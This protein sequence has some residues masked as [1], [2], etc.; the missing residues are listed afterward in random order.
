MHPCTFVS[1]P[2]NLVAG[3]YL[4]FEGVR[5]TKSADQQY[6]QRALDLAALALGR[7]SPNP[8]VGAVI[9]KDGCIVGEG[10]HRKA[11]TPHAEIHALEQ[12]GDLARG[13][14]IYVTLE[15]CSHYGKTPP[16]AQAL[17]NAGIRKVSAAV[18]DPNPKVSGRGMAML[19]QAGM[20][21]EVGL[22]ADQALKQNEA[23]F[24]AITREIPWIA[25]KT[26]MTLD[27]KIATHTGNSRW[28]TSDLAREY[29]HRLRN[30]YD[31]IMVGI[32]TV[33]ADDPLLNTRLNEEDSRDPVRVIVDGELQ[34]PA[35]SRIAQS[36]LKQRTIIFTSRKADHN[37]ENTLASLGLDIIRIDGEPDNLSLEQ[38]FKHLHGMGLN[39]VLVEGGAKLNAALMTQHWVDKIYWF[40]APKIVGGEN[41]PGPIAGAGVAD[42]SEAVAMKNWQIKTIGPDLMIEAYTGW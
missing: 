30:R 36:S 35:S 24:K 20:D 25:I 7:T 34:L 5:M 28:I 29:V 17:I 38:L 26:A 37:R 3:V 21:T 39:S 16:C 19:E 4:F 8:V 15:P 12:A 9:V 40:I 11:G 27:G 23:F 32:G 6:M 14:T 13:A 42:M 18:L 10:Y 2:R 33:L 31:A 22:L 1:K 41:A